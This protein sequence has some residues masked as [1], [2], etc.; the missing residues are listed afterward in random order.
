MTNPHSENAASTHTSYSSFAMVAT[1]SGVNL[2]GLSDKAVSRCL[3]EMCVEKAE[4]SASSVKWHKGDSPSG[5]DDRAD[6]P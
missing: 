3:G 1:D 2:W 6:G 4:H 5:V